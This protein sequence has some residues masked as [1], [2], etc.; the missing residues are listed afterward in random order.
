MRCP[1]KQIFRRL[2]GNSLLI[3]GAQS[4]YRCKFVPGSIIYA[5]RSDFFQMLPQHR[6]QTENTTK[7]SVPMVLR[8]EE[9]TNGI[10]R[11]TGDEHYFR[12]THLAFYG[13]A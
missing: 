10:R 1:I 2:Y 12:I 13:F 5:S 3:G 6:T 4:F 7:Y 11:K 8:N 9:F